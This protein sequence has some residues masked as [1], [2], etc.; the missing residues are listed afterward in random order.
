MAVFVIFVVSHFS[1]EGRT[2]VLI[3]PVPRRC[4]PFTFDQIGH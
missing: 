1:F 3:A 4:L 2:V